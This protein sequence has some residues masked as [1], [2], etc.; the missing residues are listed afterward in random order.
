MNKKYITNI[1]NEDY[2]NWNEGDFILLNAGTGNGKSHFIKNTLYDYCKENNKKILFI[3]NRDNLRKQ[4]IK[5]LEDKLDIITCINYQKIEFQNKY[6][7]HSLL[8]T[9]IWLSDFDYIVSDES[10]YFFTDSTFNTFT[11]L[12]LQ[13]ILNAK[14]TNKIP[15]K[16]FM[17]ATPTLIKSYFTDKNISIKEYVIDKDYSY[18]NRV[19]FYYD[20][21]LLEEN[22]LDNIQEDERLLYFCK[23]AEK[24]YELYKKYESKSSFICSKY[25]K[26]FSSYI[27]NEELKNII[28]NEKFNSQMLFTTMCMDNGVNIKDSSIKTIIIDCD[29]ID[30]LIQCLGRYR[31][32]NDNKV[33]VYIRAKG[34]QCMGGI[35]SVND[36]MLKMADELEVLGDYEFIRKYPREDYTK[37]IYDFPTEDNRY[38]KKVNEIMK[39]KCKE[40]I[41][42]AR[43]CIDAGK[44][45]FCNYVIPYLQRCEYEIL[46]DLFKK[47]SLEEYLESLVGK[48]LLKE[49]KEKL[50]DKIDYRI[51]GQQKKSL[52]HLNTAL[53]LEGIPYVIESKK[54]GNYRY[55][56]VKGQKV[57]KL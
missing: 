29:D 10:Q 46:D 7:W 20:Q 48:R 51:N 56:E 37:I 6:D 49:D 54:S 52:K 14:N 57:C 44:N 3:S 27:C 13:N 30:T 28:E 26:R 53:E 36:K 31:N 33:D 38:I 23:S 41:M 2:K 32:I 47:K 18:I 4:N 12:S 11:D 21:I 35:L 25:N 43:V 50:I 55:W 42:F 22:I 17:T 40:R 1:I 45:G 39:T 15:I 8:D 19:V 16:I 5:E 34:N 9:Y 24:S